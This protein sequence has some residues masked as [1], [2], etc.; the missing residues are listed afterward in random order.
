[1]AGFI[2]IVKKLSTTWIFFF[3]FKNKF[4][5]TCI[6]SNYYKNLLS[7]INKLN[8]VSLHHPIDNNGATWI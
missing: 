1:M 8:L 5:L 7:K 3:I 6:S 2:D 4:S